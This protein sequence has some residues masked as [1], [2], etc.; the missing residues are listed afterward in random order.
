MTPRMEFPTF[1]CVNHV[2][3]YTLKFYLQKTILGAESWL[4]RWNCFVLCFISSGDTGGEGY[5]FWMQFFEWNM[6]WRN[7]IDRYITC[8]CTSK[9]HFLCMFCSLKIIRK[10]TEKTCNRWVWTLNRI[11]KSLCSQIHHQNECQ[12]CVW[13]CR[14][15]YFCVMMKLKPPL[16]FTLKK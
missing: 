7:G 13:V 3:M 1:T 11:K 5:R 16:Q 9:F 12:S 10:N 2:A 14:H 15:F 8:H 6:I 4:Q